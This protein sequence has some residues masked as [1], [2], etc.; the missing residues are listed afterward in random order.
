[1]ASQ[2][3]LPANVR[4]LYVE[5]IG[6]FYSDEDPELFN[7]LPK[8]YGEISY[9]P[10]GPRYI[11]KVSDDDLFDQASYLQWNTESG[12]IRYILAVTKGTSPYGFY[13]LPD[14]VVLNRLKDAKSG[15]NFDR[16]VNLIKD[17]KLVELYNAQQ[18]KPQ[19]QKTI[20]R[21][22]DKYL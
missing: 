5:G 4:Y 9:D 11:I 3:F 15:S 20:Q 22:K 10:S 21:L 8:R 12:K 2:E 17:R 18:K 14:D 6:F 7:L 16:V 19:D 13:N 1:M